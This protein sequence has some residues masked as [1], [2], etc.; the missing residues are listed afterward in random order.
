MN[1]KLKTKIAVPG[2]ILWEGEVD[3][4]KVQT[5]TGKIGILPNHVSLITA[6]ETSVLT[7]KQDK[8]IYMVISDG[9]LSVE[10][11]CVFIAT[12]RCILEENID[13]KKLDEN[14]KIALERYNEAKKPGKK[15]IANKALKR[16]NACYE[17]INYRKNT[18]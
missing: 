11:N 1:L 9:Y 3:E 4:I 13:E 18:I 12:D 15:Y 7:L 14:Y 16:I 5:T 8:K 6:I 2:K 17:I 10:K